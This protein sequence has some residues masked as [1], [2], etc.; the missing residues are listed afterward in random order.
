[1]FGT[2]HW[3][4]DGGLASTLQNLGYS[5]DGDP[6]WSARLLA[7]DPDA[8]KRVHKTFLEA[9]ADMVTTASY[10]ASISGFVKHLSITD[11]EA[12]KLMT[13]SVSLAREAVNEYCRENQKEGEK[14]LVVGS[15]GPYGACQAD[16]S[17]YTGDY[18]S[19]M[20]EE[21][22]KVWHRPRMTALVDAGVDLLAIETIPALKEAL[23]VLRLL[24]EFPG[25]KAWVTFS[26]RDGQRTNF[27]D[28]F[29]EA[30][31]KCHEEAPDQL[32]AV[33]VNCS[34]PQHVSSLLKE[35]NVTLPAPEVLPR[36]VY[37]NSGE[38]WVA[39]KGW[40]G[41][42][43]EWSY[44]TEVPSWLRLGATVVGGCCRI[45]PEDI[46]D[47]ASIVAKSPSL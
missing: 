42:S 32:A 13:L 33:G 22:L 18:V 29:G 1:M 3:I 19:K 5:V 43:T 23:A 24:K 17:E 20:T 2:R 25:V 6:L 4:A 26:C 41:R 8:I 31:R 34:P 14:P 7:T 46:R 38:E 11:E 39:G 10:Q 28:P 45:G 16:G 40:E 27:G 12:V 44:V 47:I 30:A 35:A 15:V 9:K 36:V 21:Q 37:P